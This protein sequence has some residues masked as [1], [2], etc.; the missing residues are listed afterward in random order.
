LKIC[1]TT[2]GN[3]ARDHVNQRQIDVTLNEVVPKEGLNLFDG[4]VGIVTPYRNH[5]NALNNWLVGKNVLAST[6]DK[7]QGREREVIILNTVDN[8][9]SDFTA[10][11]NRLNVAVSR[12]IR[13]LIVVT[14]GNENSENTAIDELINYIKI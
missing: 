12:A 8:K 2:K 14:N 5:A 13:Q 11:P 1:E 9:I 7:F 10:N 3:H 4:S 6:V